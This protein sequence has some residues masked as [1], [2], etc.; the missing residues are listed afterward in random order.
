MTLRVGS[1]SRTR[2]SRQSI[3]A[4]CGALV[5]ALLM[6][7]CS[8]NTDSPDASNAAEVD[9]ANGDVAVTISDAVV[10]ETVTMSAAVYLELE[11]H[12]DAAI[13]LIS[14]ECD[15]SDVAVIHATH[16]DGGLAQM[17]HVEAINIPAN[18]RVSL[19]PAGEHIMLETIHREL[20]AGDT[21]EL[22]LG[23]DSGEEQTVNVPVVPLADLAE[24]V[25]Q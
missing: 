18:A 4:S 16:H 21:I 1:P 22:R 6:M 19:H 20:V 7:G 14:A 2:P 13:S 11:N 23:F 5:L 24:R 3:A 17:V 8:S 25:P 10:G 12:T 9:P 15:C